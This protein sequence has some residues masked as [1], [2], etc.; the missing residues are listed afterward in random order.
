MSTSRCSVCG[1]KLEEIK[2]CIYNQFELYVCDECCEDC[3]NG[4]PYPC[5]FYDKRKITEIEKDEENKQED[6]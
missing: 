6:K 1:K 3:R 2:Q 4:S 5:S